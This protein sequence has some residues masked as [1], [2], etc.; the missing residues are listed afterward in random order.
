MRTDQEVVQRCLAGDADAYATLVERYGGR[1]YNIAL[2]ITSDPDA[3]S[4]CAQEAFIRAYKALH[5]YDPAQ[6]FGPW[7]FRIATNASLNHV[8]RWHAHQTPVQELP[9]SPA[10]EESGPEASALRRE[11][12][13]EV[14]AAMAELPP[15]YRA[16]LALRHMQQLSYQEVADTLGI[17]L[18][19]VKTHLHRARAAL[20][21]RLDARKREAQA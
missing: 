7:I 14:L 4:D 17:P 10:P 13:S 9:E 18:G 6:P 2:R 16:A 15:P 8:Q 21:T 12:V 3:A 19:T 5:Q 11:A 1:V 20:K